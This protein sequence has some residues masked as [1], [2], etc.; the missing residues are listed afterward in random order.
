MNY[1][2]RRT[3]EVFCTDLSGEVSHREVGMGSVLTSGSLC[4]VVVNTLAQNAS[5][6]G[7]NPALGA[8]FPRD[9]CEPLNIKK[10]LSQLL[11]SHLV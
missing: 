3:S 9:A 7:L 6:V 5:D 10:A 8:I 4:G 2:S 11:P 1:N